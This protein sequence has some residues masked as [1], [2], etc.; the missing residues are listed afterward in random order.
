M[1]VATCMSAQVKVIDAEGK[2]CE[3]GGVMVF[4]SEATV[5]VPTIPPIISFSSPTLVNTT[6]NPVKVS[7]DIT[8]RQLPEGTNFSDCFS[9]VCVNYGENSS[10][11]TAT[12]E[13]AAN[14][15]LPTQ[16]EWNNKISNG[17]YAE[18]TCIA[19]FTLYVDGK[20]TMTFTA[21]YIHGGEDA[22][23]E[24][25]QPNTN[26]STSYTLDGKPVRGNAKGLIVRNGKKVLVK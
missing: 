14:D 4:N 1:F 11:T 5:I 13:I 19:D 22:M 26:K 9:G 10:H 8:V 21:K 2:A 23:K 12:K 18:G 20:K 7:M 15:K 3:D 24:I 25:A 16:I 17:V 6:G